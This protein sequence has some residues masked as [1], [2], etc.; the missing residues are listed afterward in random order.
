[1]K[2]NICHIFFEEYPKDTR[3]RRYVNFIKKYDY[4]V[5]IICLKTPNMRYVESNQNE[6][7]FRIP[8]QKKRSSFIRRI[9]EYFQFQVFATLL[10][11]YVCLVHNVRLFHVHTL[12]DFLVFSCLIAKAANSRI[13]LDFHELFPESMSQMTGKNNNSITIKMIKLQEKLSYLFANAI[14]AF[15]DPAR[16]ILTNRYKKY[17]KRITTVMNS[18]DTD[19]IPI[20]KKIKSHKLIIVYNGTINENL[21]LT[22]VVETLNR[23]RVTNPKLF[24]KIEYRLYGDGPDL[25]NILNLSK[26]YNLNNV[27]YF[28]RL[29]YK[30]MIKELSQASLCILPPKKDVYSDLYYSLKLIEMIYLKVPVIATRLN[31]YQKYY[32]ECCILYFDSMDMQQLIEKIEFFYNNPTKVLKY[33]EKAFRKYQDYNWTKNSENYLQV[34]H[35]LVEN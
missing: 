27:I 9:W 18:I 15:H 34:I 30:D 25:K 31:T 7:I 5:F 6:K 32:P 13:I 28:G 11:S 23:L 14:I 1:M 2:K 29:K 4:K 12:P 3:I 21:N 24:Y 8:I 16:E 26:K 22:F 33:T 17:N 35:R 20:I 10:A 19:E